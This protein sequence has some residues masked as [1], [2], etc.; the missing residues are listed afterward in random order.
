MK[1]RLLIDGMSEL[2]LLEL[3][4]DKEFQEIIFMDKPLI[5]T[6]GT[7]EILGQ[8][9]REEDSMEIILSHIDGGGEGV[10]L[11]I[12]N[13]FREFGKQQGINEIDWIVHAADCPKP[14]P[15]LKRILELK[16][17]EMVN[18]ERD[19]L[20]YQKVEQLIE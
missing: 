20:V 7:S 19:G 2:E 1:N 10:L 17:F 8:F 18:H 16:G 14:N 6:A 13:L 3:A 5:F 15:K 11:R 9:K 12:T 4:K